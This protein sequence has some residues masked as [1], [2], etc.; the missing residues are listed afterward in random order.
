MYK[1]HNFTILVVL[2]SILG[3]IFYHLD[4]HWE[5]EDHKSTRVLSA[6]SVGENQHLDQSQKNP[7]KEV[8]NTINEET[9]IGEDTIDADDKAEQL[10]DDASQIMVFGTCPFMLNF[11]AVGLIVNV[12]IIAACHFC[13]KPLIRIR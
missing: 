4:L 8:T 6:T 5:S 7:I 10:S 11:L 13:K 2:S 12:M 1:W 3:S 9:E